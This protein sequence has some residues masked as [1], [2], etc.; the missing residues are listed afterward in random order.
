MTDSAT[1]RPGKRPRLRP[2]QKQKWERS[3]GSARDRRSA[4]SHDTGRN[5]SSIIVCRSNRFFDDWWW[6]RSV[7]RERRRRRNEKSAGRRGFRLSAPA[8]RSAA[9]NAAGSALSRVRSLAANRGPRRVEGGRAERRA[10]DPS[11]VFFRRRTRRRR[12]GRR[13]VVVVAP[14]R[15]ARKPRPGTSPPGRVAGQS[16]GRLDRAGGTRGGVSFGRRNRV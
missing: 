1:R 7:R 3:R 16:G 10:H 4:T 15:V 12:G 14:T 8:R 11:A 6:W 5:V 13:R 9:A 2:S